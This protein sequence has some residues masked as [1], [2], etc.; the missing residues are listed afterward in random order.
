MA[1][2]N[3]YNQFG[4]WLGCID[5]DSAEDAIKNAADQEYLNVDHVTLRSELEGVVGH[6]KS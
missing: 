4:D 6:G 5:G 1:K 3:C 2:W